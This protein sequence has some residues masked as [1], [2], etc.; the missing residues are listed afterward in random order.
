MW[1]FVQVQRRLSNFCTTWHHVV[2]ISLCHHAIFSACVIQSVVFR[3]L[4]K[5]CLFTENL[6]ETRTTQN[7]E[8]SNFVNAVVLRHLKCIKSL[9]LEGITP[10]M[11]VASCTEVWENHLILKILQESPLL[12]HPF[13]YS[14]DGKD[15]GAGKCYVARVLH[16]STF[17]ISYY[18]RNF[19]FIDSQFKKP[20]RHHHST[21]GNGWPKFV[22]GVVRF[23]F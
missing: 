20:C 8:D 12:Y 15:K 22:P 13:E 16:F 9:S 4:G 11:K 6:K 14:W 19:Q 3:Q 21:L 18:W 7:K 17:A 23:A 2:S 10:H 5:R 1:T